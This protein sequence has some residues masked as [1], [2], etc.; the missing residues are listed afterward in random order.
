M[1]LAERVLRA[2]LRKGASQTELGA[3]A[4]VS[5]QAVNQWESGSTKNLRGDPLLKAAAYLGVNPMWLS[6][7]QGPELVRE[8]VVEKPAVE[9]DPEAHE[10]LRAQA[11]DIVLASLAHAVNK[12]GVGKVFSDY[13]R[14]LA[15][16]AE[17]LPLRT[18]KGVL[19]IA[20]R[21]AE[22]KR[23]PLAKTAPPL[24]RRGSVRSRS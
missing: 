3:A 24:Q 19:G 7:E 2:R 1:T 23:I 17:P 10:N 21:N 5:S 22:A 13:L 20:L 12:L 14:Q 9:V 15:K 18:D 6:R 8:P 4:G 11:I 16:D